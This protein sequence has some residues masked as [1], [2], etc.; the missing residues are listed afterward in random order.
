MQAHHRF[1]RHA[2]SAAVAGLMMLGAGCGPDEQVVAETP[3]IEAET[4]RLQ[5]I[6]KDLDAKKA[7]LEKVAS[8]IEELEKQVDVIDFKA[9]KGVTPTLDDKDDLVR[10]GALKLLGNGDLKAAQRTVAKVAKDR[11]YLV[12]EMIQSDGA[13]YAVVLG[14]DIPAASDDVN[15]DAAHAKQAKLWKELALKSNDFAK[16]HAAYMKAERAAREADVEGRKAKEHMLDEW[17]KELAVSK[18]R[19]NQVQKLLK[20]LFGGK[21][22]VL[23]SGFIK[24]DK[25]VAWV[26]GELAKKK[27]AKNLKALAKKTG[28]KV[29]DEPEGLEPLPKGQARVFLQV[30][31]PAAE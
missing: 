28:A 4:K 12:F 1:A 19:L 13:Q 26:E 31:T 11:P 30:F 6:A 10:S 29:V 27:K 3:K 9:P 8:E 25:G 22:P 21:K 23:K 5:D 20:T 18:G 2:L 24:I 16:L 15:E 17:K 7:A 14:V